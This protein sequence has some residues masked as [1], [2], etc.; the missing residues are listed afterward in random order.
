M[1]HVPLRDLRNFF[2]F[3]TEI[4]DTIQGGDL[5]IAV[6]RLLEAIDAVGGPDLQ[7]AASAVARIDGWDVIVADVLDADRALA[8][9]G[10]GPC[11]AVALNLVNRD[12]DA[13]LGVVRFFYA[14]ATPDPQ[15]PLSPDSSGRVWSAP[16]R[17]PVTVRGL[18]AAMAIERRPD[19]PDAELAALLV[20]VRYHEA[21]EAIL[22]DPGLPRAIVAFVG[23][24]HVAWPMEAGVWDYGPSARRV[25]TSR[26]TPVTAAVEA[27][28]ARRRADEARE[29]LDATRGILT[30]VRE[31]RALLLAWP[32]WRGWSERPTAIAVFE[33]G[34]KIMAQTSGLPPPPPWHAR[35]AVFD[36]FLR[37]YAARRHPDRPDDALVP[38]EGDDRGALHE[39]FVAHA[40]RFGGPAVRLAHREAAAQRR[41]TG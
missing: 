16:G 40:L 12:T 10:G 33:S 23:V 7:A 20:L 19:A 17:V 36:A 9:R 28:L 8:A 3:Q 37:S 26:E 29:H 38:L 18:E 2:A 4:V 39:L 5:P 13:D 11:A 24:D 34:T 32:W 21:V 1:D 22:A 31:K 41:R 14:A 6:A 30:E 27:I 25:V 35:D 15:Y